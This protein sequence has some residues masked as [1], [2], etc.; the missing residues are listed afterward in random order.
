M[1]LEQLLTILSKEVQL[2]RSRPFNIVLEGNIGSGKSTFLNY[3]QHN[4]SVSID[5][6]PLDSW[7]NCDGHNLLALQ[8]EDPSKWSATLQSFVQLTMLQLHLKPVQQP[9]RMIERSIYSAR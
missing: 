2:P 3:F 6:E 7:C 1:I 4:K 9:I 8:Y 5:S